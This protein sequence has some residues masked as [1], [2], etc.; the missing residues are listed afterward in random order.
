MADIV[1]EVEISHAVLSDGQPVHAAGEAIIADSA[2]T[3]YFGIE[4]SSRGGH[5]VGDNQELREPIRR[6]GIPF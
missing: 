4:I 3:G 2:E 6:L 1:E 5:F